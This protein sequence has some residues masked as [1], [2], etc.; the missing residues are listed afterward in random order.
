MA[1]RHK[2]VKGCTTKWELVRYRTSHFSACHNNIPAIPTPTVAINQYGHSTQIVQLNVEHESTSVSAPVWYRSFLL[3]TS[4]VLARSLPTPPR[5]RFS[6][7]YYFPTPSAPKEQTVCVHVCL[8]GAVVF[9]PASLLLI[10]D[11]CCDDSTRKLVLCR[12]QE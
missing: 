6:F 5:T 7:S 2:N 8:C 1:D 10:I 12:Q 11:C 3:P 9:R 4:T